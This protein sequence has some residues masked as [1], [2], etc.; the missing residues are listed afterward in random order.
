MLILIAIGAMLSYQRPEPLSW[1]SS[2]AAEN[3]RQAPRPHGPR[4]C[5]G[6]ADRFGT[7]RPR[8]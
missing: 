6:D 4:I 7:L 8:Q 1:P 3:M 5:T 2:I